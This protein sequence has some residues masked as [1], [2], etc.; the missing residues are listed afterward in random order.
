M[1]RLHRTGGFTLLELLAV[2]V[3]M[4]TVVV[5]VVP[6][7]VGTSGAEVEA[8]ARTLAAGLRRVRSQA[9]RNHR[10]QSLVLDVERRSFRLSF[11]THDRSLP[12]GVELKMVTAREALASGERGAIRFFPN[13]GSSGGQITV[14][15]AAREIVLDVDWLSGRVRMFNG[16]RDARLEHGGDYSERSARNIA[17]S[18][19]GVRPSGS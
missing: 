16:R 8:A 7:L 9:I 2:L 14:A 4:A 12:E 1:K 17:S 3:V 10:P 6:A 18:G 13:G 5:A 15:G 11:E 19:I